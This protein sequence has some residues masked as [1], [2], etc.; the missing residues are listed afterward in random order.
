M[1]EVT[2]TKNFHLLLMMFGA[3]HAHVAEGRE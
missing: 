2:V 3:L 1:G